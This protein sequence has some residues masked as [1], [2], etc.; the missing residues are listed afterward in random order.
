MQAALAGRRVLPRLEGR[1]GGVDRAVHVL[2]AAL[3]APRPITSSSTGLMI[4]SA[5]PSTASTILPLTKFL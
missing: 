1:R 2:L 4:G 5:W 3:A